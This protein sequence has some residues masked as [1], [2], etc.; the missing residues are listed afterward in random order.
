LKLV[1]N[2]DVS[3]DA[4]GN[5]HFQVTGTNELI[6]YVD[7]IT[8]EIGLAFKTALDIY[9]SDNMPFTPYEIPSV[10]IF[11]AGG[12]ATSMIHTPADSVKN[13]GQKGYDTTIK[14]SI[15]L[16]NRV[17]NAKVYPIKKEIDES[18][19]EKI[20]KYLFNLNYEKPKLYWKQ[21]YEK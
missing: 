12:K 13:V 3:G 20:E 10:N 5:D 11:R 15:N 9:S 21:K 6:G 1:V 4:I 2:I 19:R 14:S 7:G 16:L 8:K 17:L 18:L